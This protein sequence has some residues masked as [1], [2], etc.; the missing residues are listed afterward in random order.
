MEKK[1]VVLKDKNAV[2]PAVI[3]VNV[4][5]EMVVQAFLAKYEG[6]FTFLLPMTDELITVTSTG[7]VTGAKCLN[8]HAALAVMVDTEPKPGIKVPKQILHYDGLGGIQLFSWPADCIPWQIL[9]TKMLEAL[10]ASAKA[11]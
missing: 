5:F 1:F 3:V 10:V 6:E 11:Y 2:K 7:P 8:P 9:A 4:E